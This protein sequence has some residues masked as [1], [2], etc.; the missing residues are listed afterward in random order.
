VTHARIHLIRHRVP[1]A[2]AAGVLKRAAQKQRHRKIE[3]SE[4]HRERGHEHHRRFD[5]RAAVPPAPFAKLLVEPFHA[6]PCSE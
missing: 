3:N 5:E 1:H 2:L 6:I 4:H